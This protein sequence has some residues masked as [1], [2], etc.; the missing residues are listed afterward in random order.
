MSFSTRSKRGG[1]LVAHMNPL[2]LLLATQRVC[3]AVQRVADHAIHTLYAG[4]LQSLSD[5]ISHSSGHEKRL[6][7]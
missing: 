6:E 7:K 1:L 5:E 2:D 3:E 4:L